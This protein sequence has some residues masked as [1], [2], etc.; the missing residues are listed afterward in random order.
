MGRKPR[1]PP[2]LVDDSNC[3]RQHQMEFGAFR[4]KNE[5]CDSI[6]NPLFRLLLR[7]VRKALVTLDRR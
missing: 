4:V 2:L 5:S 1:S 6:V 7:S 3:K